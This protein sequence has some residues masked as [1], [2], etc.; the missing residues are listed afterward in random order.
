MAWKCCNQEAAG[1]LGKSVLPR[2]LWSN[3]HYLCHPLN[4]TSASF[5]ALCSRHP[6][7][8]RYFSTASL[9]FRRKDWHPLLYLRRIIARKLRCSSSYTDEVVDGNASIL[10]SP[11]TTAPSTSRSTLASTQ[12]SWQLVTLALQPLFLPPSY[13]RLSW[14]FLMLDCLSDQTSDTLLPKVQSLPKL[15]VFLFM[16]QM[17]TYPALARSSDCSASTLSCCHSYRSLLFAMP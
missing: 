12:A 15:A 10:T 5:T 7:P 1:Y 11:P 16:Q 8:W 6:F 9:C 13:L 2:V 4:R 14:I 17:S 3:L